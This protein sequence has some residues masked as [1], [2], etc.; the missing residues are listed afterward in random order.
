MY[1]I[2]NFLNNDDI[3]VTYKMGAFRVAEYKRDLSVTKETAQREYFASQMGV[4]LKQLVCD[5]KQG[6]VTVQAGS[7]QWMI[8]DVN[9][10]SGIKGVGDFIGKSLRSTVTK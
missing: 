3:D 1:K 9:A 2:D 7:M 5:L 8:G 10:S 6:P 4:R